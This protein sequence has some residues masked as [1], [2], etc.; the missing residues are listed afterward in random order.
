[1]GGGLAEKRFSVPSWNF[2]VRIVVL[3]SSLTP[4]FWKDRFKSWPSMCPSCNG[5]VLFG[6]LYGDNYSHRAPLRRDDSC[7]SCKQEF[8]YSD[9]SIFGIL[10][11]DSV[12]ELIVED[13]MGL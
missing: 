13:L 11:G 1:M 10:F 6:P 5:G 7:S 2:D 12:D 4:A 9:S 3:H 8:I